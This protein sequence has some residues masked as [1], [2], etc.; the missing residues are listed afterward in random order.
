M[1]FFATIFHYK[2]NSGMASKDERS[3]Y[4]TNF[5]T[6]VTED[7][8]KELFIQVSFLVFLKSRY[9]VKY[10]KIHQ[11]GPVETVFVKKNDT[12]NRDFALIAFVHPE[13][14]LFAVETLDE[15]RL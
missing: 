4:I 8:L 2:Y 13:S 12:G 10:H 1:L 15:V 7:L 14:V 11:V 3:V 9:V 5:T 6:E